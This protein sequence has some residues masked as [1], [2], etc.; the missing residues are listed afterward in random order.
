MTENNNNS[1]KDQVDQQQVN[2]DNEVDSFGELGL[3]IDLDTDLDEILSNEEI[4]D[5]LEQAQ[6]TAKDYQLSQAS[7][8]SSIDSV[9]VE[10][11]SIEKKEADEE[12]LECLNCSTPLTGPYCHDC[13]QPERHFIRF[14]PKVLWEM[15]NEAF[16]LDSKVLRTILPLY[17]IPGRLSMEYFAGRR[18][19]YV[20][21]LRLYIILSILFFITLSISTGGETG[22]VITN[23][24]NGVNLR[25]RTTNDI[26]AVDPHLE[27]K[28]IV[29][30]DG[31]LNVTLGN[32][33]PWNLETNPLTFNDMFNE[34]TTKELNQFFW[35]LALKL[36]K[37]VKDD[38]KELLNEFLNVIPQLMFI[39]LPIFALLL[40]LTYVFKKRYYMEH[41]I[42]ALHNHCFMFLS[43]MLLILVGYVQDVL[44]SPEWLIDALSYLFI[45]ML[46][47]VPLYLFI[48]MKRVYAQGYTMTMIKFIFITISYQL[49]LSVTAALAFALGLYYI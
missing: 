46:L 32:D 20:N 11:L 13:G 44:A 12:S 40:K 42:V 45:I 24:N 5:K 8:P 30:Q 38:P 41:L 10:D 14:F 18:A 48:T 6:S 29:D 33:K 17:F 28:G 23:E 15:V 4:A 2:L 26:E 1:K 19:R 21:P 27:K 43:L 35:A 22:A 31:Q 3:E 36:D 34:E 16:D 47:W 9:S 37:V 39:L 25:I 49:L 7:K